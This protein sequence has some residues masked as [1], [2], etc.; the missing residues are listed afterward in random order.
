MK[1][2][3]RSKL[4]FRNQ[5]ALKEYLTAKDIVVINWDL[6]HQY[7]GRLINIFNKINSTLHVPY[8]GNIGE[9]VINAYNT[10]RDNDILAKMRNHGRA[11]ESVYFVWMQ[12]YIA[13]NVFQPMIESILEVKLEQ[14]GKDDLTNPK[15]FLRRA[16]PDLVDH[17]KKVYVEFQAGFKG[18]KT[19][20]KK[21][22]V[23]PK[24]PN[25]TYYIVCLDCFNGDYCIINAR[26]LLNLP[27]DQWYPNPL[28]ENALCYTVPEKA[29]QTWTKSHQITDFL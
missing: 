10:I 24:D 1:K 18:G 4:G 15:E 14:N 27:D 19:D 8:E 12:G 22:K 29:L 11:I 20:I 16:D 23:N 28:W 9:L 13:A 6:I 3:Y 25:Y 21:S 5:A 7:N 26:E 17:D 2:D